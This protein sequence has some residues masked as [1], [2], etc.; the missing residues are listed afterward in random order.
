MIKKMF[1]L[2]FLI[3][4]TVSL[5][6]A[7]RSYVIDTPCHGLLS[8]S[9]YNLGFNF[10]SQG[11]VIS[12]IDFGV[13]K[14][15]NVGLS[16]EL[17]RFIGDKRI[18]AVFPALQMKLKVYNGNMILPAVSVGYD[19]QDYLRESRGAYFVV[20][21]EVFIEN[22]I[23]NVGISVNPFRGFTNA[24]FLFY[25][26]IVSFMVEYD[27]INISDYKHAR[28]NVGL[29]FALTKRFD[30]DYIIRDCLGKRI[31]N[32][33]NKDLRVPNEKILKI[34]YFGKF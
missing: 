21:K 24:T 23:F 5:A 28:F 34:N 2:M 18:K 27:N 20:G 29:K 13:L 31:E 3:F 1:I 14:F 30:V 15:L 4:A 7:S 12:K 17:D 25:K 26:E 8:C 6:F 33:E 10:F 11:G 22:L 16:W 19:G 9:S 32:F